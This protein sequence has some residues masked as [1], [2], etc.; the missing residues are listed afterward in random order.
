MALLIRPARCIDGDGTALPPGSG[1]LVEAGV[2]QAV[3]RGLSAAEVLDLP[4]ATLLPG[5]IDLHDYLSVDPDRPNPMAQMH[6]A[7]MALRRAVAARQM[8][9]DLAAG[10]TTL[11]VMGE[12][13]GLDVALLREA[14]AGPLLV[15]SGAPIAAPGTHQ[16]GPEGGYA[17]PDDVARA[18]DARAEGGAAWI[19]LVPTGGALGASATETPWGRAHIQAAMRRAR[20]LG[21]PVAVAAHGGPIVAIAAE[22]G[23]ATLEHGAFLDDAALDAMAANGMA[24]VATLGRFLHPDGM[25]RGAAATTVERARLAAACDSIRRWVP[26]VLARGIAIGLGG[27]NM[28]GRQAWDAAALVQLGADPARA[29]AALTGTAARLCRLPDRGFLRPGLRADL[30]AVAG[31]PLADPVALQ[32]VHRVFQGGIG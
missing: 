27:D 17:T 8:A 16:A 2:I 24:L 30:V 19:K 29:I 15:P 7:D 32:R 12:G 10:V 14:A 28:H 1:V 9:M 4:G 11:R 22:E 3:G 5:F 21:L 31:D 25:A 23:A 6:G 20:A 18:V 13:G 26:Q